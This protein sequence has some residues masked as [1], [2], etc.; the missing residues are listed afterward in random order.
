MSDRTPEEGLHWLSVGMFLWAG[1]ALVPLVGFG[2]ILVVVGIGQAYA[3]LMPGVDPL[4]ALLWAAGLLTFAAL[5]LPS[6]YYAVMRLAGRRSPIASGAYSP[7][8]LAGAGALIL[9]ALFAGNWVSQ[10]PGLAI[11]LLPGLHILAVGL[12]VALISLIGLRRLSAGSRQRTWGA[13]AS[14]LT[15]APLGALILEAL[16]L[17][18]GFIFLGVYL[19]ARPDLAAELETLSQ[20]LMIAPPSQA[21]IER[22]LSPYLTSPVTIF[23]VLSYLAGIVPLIEE[24]LK[25]A[26]VWLLAGRGVTPEQ[27]FAIGLL[28]G[29]GYALFENML[30][31][32]GGAPWLEP[33]LV[34]IGAGLLHITA[35]ALTGWA[36]AQAWQDGNYL[37][38]GL[39][40][41]AA[42]AAH[43]IW[44]AFSVLN[45]GVELLGSDS[46]S[47]GWQ[48][49]LNPLWMIVILVL[50]VGGVTWV[51]ADLLRQKAARRA[52]LT[53][54]P[55]MLAAA[56]VVLAD[57]AEAANAEP[58]FSQPKVD[59]SPAPDALSE[60]QA[61]AQADLAE[62]PEELPG[63]DLPATAPPV[64][65]DVNPV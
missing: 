36:I 27:G 58:V 2:L 9:L 53:Q 47:L 23:L 64:D 14:G 63:A 54:A 40:Y 7:L 28:G 11:N 4:P 49:A 57:A 56:P 52:S 46:L 16:A 50:L 38:L 19:T 17:L 24:F 44:N 55:E 41:L 29:A 65:S 30:F 43:G 48:I 34:R 42:V 39:V 13:L 15:L 33:V 5:L 37:R 20:R 12:P 31:T 10:R 3:N 61:T 51:R 8:L 26:A 60:P 32:A 59:P 25:P 45:A 21:T 22:L 6:M 62:F 35:S 18:V 1:L